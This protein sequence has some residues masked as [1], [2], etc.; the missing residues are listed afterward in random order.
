L[1][2]PHRNNAA[3]RESK[4]HGVKELLDTIKLACQPAVQAPPDPNLGARAA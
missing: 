4:T 3:S 2:L 1:F